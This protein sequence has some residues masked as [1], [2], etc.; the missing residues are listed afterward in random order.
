MITP[1]QKLNIT[2]SMILLSVAGL[3]FIIGVC[4]QQPIVYIPAL[5]VAALA[6]SWLCDVTDDK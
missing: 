4:I 1:K 6:I 3:T 5:V 2:L